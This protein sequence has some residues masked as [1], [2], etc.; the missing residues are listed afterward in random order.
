[1]DL[2]LNARLAVLTILSGCVSTG[3]A[4]CPA[5]AQSDQPA[6]TSVDGRVATY[7]DRDLMGFQYPPGTDPTAGARMIGLSPGAVSLATQGYDHGWPI[8]PGTNDPAGSQ[9]YPNTDQ[10][11]V[12]SNQTGQHD[13][14]AGFDGRKQGPALFSLDY[15]QLVPAGA[16]NQTLTLGIA[17]DDF[18]FPAWGQPFSATVNGQPNDALTRELNTID[19]TGPDTRYLSVGIDP[20]ILTPNH[21]LTVAIDEGGDGGDGFAFDF[22]TVGVTT[23]AGGSAPAAYAASP[24]PS[25]ASG[26]GAIT[27]KATVLIK[28]EP[29]VEIPLKQEEK[30]AVMFMEAISFLEGDCHMHMSR[31]CSLGELVAGPKSPSWNIGRLKY[32][33]ARDTNYRY[34]ITITAQGWNASANPQSPGLGGFFY[35][36]DHGILV[37]RY[38]N[39]NG[40]ASVKDKKLGETSVSGEIFQ[41][42]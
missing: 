9:D 42:H 12:G 29:G 28:D 6:P 36:L 33:P 38:Y 8:T 3:L 20:A 11:F 37:D 23:S 17:A 35:D 16:R 21:I 1:M 19:E 15:G 2:N 27:T 26:S 18:Q 14:Y 7:G 30:I 10:I 32:D 39:P 5:A 22:L 31:Y 40:P 4:A 13:G 34:T 41:V 25:G 24:H